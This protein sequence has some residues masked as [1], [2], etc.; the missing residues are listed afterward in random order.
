EM[1][2]LEIEDRPDAL[3][4]V[5]RIQNAQNHLQQLYEEVRNYA[6]PLKLER[7][8]RPVDAIW[9]QAWANLAVRRQGRDGTLRHECAGVD[10]HCAVDPFRL[11]QVFRNI[12]EN[13]LAACP[14]PVEITIL[15]S[16]ASLE[17]QAAICIAVRD[18][19]PGL[20]P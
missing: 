5:G 19:G 14:D 6:A 4:R 10:L 9:H 20:N 15:C 18:N 12:L 1:L 17:G 3:N 13:A 11:E 7:Q 2:A 8:H 16:A